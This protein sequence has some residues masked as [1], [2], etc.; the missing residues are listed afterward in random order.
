MN[1]DLWRYSGPGHVNDMDILQVGRG[2]TYDEDKTHFT[3]WCIMN[4]PLIAGNDLTNMSDETLA[5]L[6][7]EEVIAL[8]QD[9]M[10]YQAR[11]LVDNGDHEFGPSLWFRQLAA[12]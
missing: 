9:P 12:R 2:M 3:M 7:N 4:S 5:I 8:N 1:A 10:V 6:T 11:R